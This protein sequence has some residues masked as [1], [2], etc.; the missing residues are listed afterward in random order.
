MRKAS[1]MNEKQRCTICLHGQRH[2]IDA[3]LARGGASQRDI[4]DLFHVGR[5]ALARHY[6]RHVLQAVRDQIRRRQE[7]TDADLTETWTA[8][9]E[10]TYQ[11]AREGADRAKADPEKWA[12]AV[13]FLHVMAKSAETGMKATG[14]LQTDRGT[15]VNFEQIFVLPRADDDTFEPALDADVIDVKALPTAPE[16]E[17]V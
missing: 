5:N 15:T 7:R 2:A 17:E 13:G 9:L 10:H 1:R 11:L 12:A 6:E 16:E 4:A 8:R 14:E 3:L